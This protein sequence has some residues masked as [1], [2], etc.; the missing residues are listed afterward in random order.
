MVIWARCKNFSCTNIWNITHSNHLFYRPGDSYVPPNQGSGAIFTNTRPSTEFHVFWLHERKPEICAKYNH[1]VDESGHWLMVFSKM[2]LDKNWQKACK[3]YRENG[4]TG[5]HSLCVSTAKH[6][7]NAYEETG[8]IMFYC[9]PSH[10]PALIRSYGENLVNLMGYLEKDGHM[11]YW[12]D[13]PR[14]V[15]LHLE[16]PSPWRRRDSKLDR[17]WIGC[18]CFLVQL[19]IEVKHPVIF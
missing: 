1:N 19:Q 9:G 4:L 10:N 11:T 3:M 2:W 14:R 6:Q 5:I 16:V 8:I 13:N 12:V 18:H 17:L 7:S 15:H